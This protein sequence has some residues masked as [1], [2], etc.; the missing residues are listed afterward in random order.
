[1][2]KFIFKIEDT[3]LDK[4]ILRDIKI[5]SYHPIQDE[6]D[7]KFL[8]N[9]LSLG[10]KKLFLETG[11]LK[12]KEINKKQRKL[13][14]ELPSNHEEIF[15]NIDEYCQQLLENFINTEKEFKT[16]DIEWNTQEI[17]Y[18]TDIKDSVLKITI[19]DNTTINSN[20]NSI[21]IEEINIGDSVAVVLGLD[22]VSLLIDTMEARTK[23]FCYFIKVHKPITYIKEEREKI[24]E[25]NFTAKKKTEQIFIKTETN[26]A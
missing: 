25:W 10:L 9:K 11:Y 15:D 22:S 8:V 21:D 26:F 19:N 24:E 18:V 2:E 17:E 7:N 4:D 16:W 20:N 5:S 1:M 3:E 14:V 23:L 13:Y 12:V 6:N